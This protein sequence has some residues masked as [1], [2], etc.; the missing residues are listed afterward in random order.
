[1]YNVA[2]LVVAQSNSIFGIKLTKLTKTQRKVII[3]LPVLCLQGETVSSS[4]SVWSA[5]AS[6]AISRHQHQ[7]LHPTGDSEQSQEEEERGEVCVCVCVCVRACVRAC[8]WVCVSMCEQLRWD[9]SAHECTILKL[10]YTYMKCTFT[11]EFH[12]SGNHLCH[13]SIEPTCSLS[14]SSHALPTPFLPPLLSS[15]TH[16]QL[17]FIH[18]VYTG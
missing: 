13:F 10:K 17:H 3:K 2:Y 7:P 12:C 9:V 14:S 18:T 6:Q 4:H 1:M 11:S 16:S 8:V 5:A 15:H